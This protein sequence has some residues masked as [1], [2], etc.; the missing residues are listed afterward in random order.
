MITLTRTPAAGQEATPAETP[1]YFSYTA[2]GD[3]IPFFDC[4]SDEDAFD[5]A[6]SE[7]MGSGHEILKMKTRSSEP[8]L[9]CLNI[10]CISDRKISPEEAS[11]ISV[12]ALGLVMECPVLEER[13][14]PSDA[15]RS[16]YPG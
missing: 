7:A 1:A 13:F 9:P 14:V 12:S 11:R 4:L 6:A 2:I 8:D 3:T 10:V 15:S 5:C 16:S